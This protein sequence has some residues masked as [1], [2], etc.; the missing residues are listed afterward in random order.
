MRDAEKVNSQ[1]A[2]LCPRH[3][4]L[5]FQIQ[6]AHSSGN[7]PDTIQLIDCNGA[8]ENVFSYFLGDEQLV[9]DWENGPHPAYSFTTFNDSGGDIL[10]AIE[11]GAALSFCYSDAFTLATGDSIEVSYN[12]LLNSGTLPNMYLGM[13]L[14]QR[15][16]LHM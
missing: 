4:F 1:D 3:K 7:H 10:T 15:L 2:L 6:T 5:P 14:Q 16:I 13:F 11:S 8:A 9:T 12:M